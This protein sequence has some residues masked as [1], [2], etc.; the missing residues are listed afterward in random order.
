[1]LFVMADPLGAKGGLSMLYQESPD[2]ISGL[3]ML[4]VDQG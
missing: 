2:L 3:V 4:L 1:M